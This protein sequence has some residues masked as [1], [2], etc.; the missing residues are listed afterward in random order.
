MSEWYHRL[1]RA[2]TLIELLV[3]VA[4]IAILAAMLLPALSAAREKARRSVCAGQ[5]RQIG[6]ALT[7]YTSDYN[8][9]FP[10]WAGY[11]GLT[12]GFSTTRYPDH[13]TYSDARSGIAVDTI[14][15]NNLYSNNNTNTWRYQGLWLRTLGKGAQR[16][17]RTPAAGELQAAPVGLGFILAGGYLDDAR[18]FYCPSAT[19]MPCTVPTSNHYVNYTLADWRTAGGYNSTVLTHGA[20][21]KKSSNPLATHHHKTIL[22][23]YVYR[24]L[25]ES[26][27][28][29]GERKVLYTKPVVKTNT[30]CPPFKT[31]RLLGGRALV[32]DSFSQART[33]GE[34]TTAGVAD[35]LYAHRDGYNALHGDGH[36]AWFGDPQQ[37]MV[38]QYYDVSPA[39]QPCQSY[40]N[41]YSR[42][43]V[44]PWRNEDKAKAVS[45]VLWHDF[46]L[47][48][49]LD[50]DAAMYPAP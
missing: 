23:H 29:G 3:V 46:D 4:I 24:N 34:R 19:N 26:D 43:L 28:W 49:G 44:Y 17:A 35:G 14:T 10:S 11:G 7:S 22:S 2:F 47:K 25:P 21:P 13:G 16:T 42:S 39:N 5:I 33:F 48:G 18:S 50:V 30:G 36:V 37:R 45:A 32:V 40:I 8:D 6:L 27:P 38:W 9:Y 31:Q 12:E 41:A 20:W 1:V 15:P